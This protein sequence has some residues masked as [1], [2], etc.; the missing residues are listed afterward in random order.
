MG[1]Q[2]R[3]CMAGGGEVRKGSS[4]LQRGLGGLWGGGGIRR[5]QEPQREAEKIVV[6]CCNHWSRNGCCCPCCPSMLPWR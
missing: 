1:A 4:G 6:P 5:D 3:G 2:V